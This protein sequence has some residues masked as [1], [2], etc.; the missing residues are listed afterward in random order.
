MALAREYIHGATV[1]GTDAEHR[2]GING[3]GNP[4]KGRDNKAHSIYENSV[5]S[6]DLNTA[7]QVLKCLR[8][9]G[10]HGDRLWQTKLYNWAKDAFMDAYDSGECAE[11]WKRTW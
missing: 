11:A 4:S 6:G 1:G 3:G 10:E 2:R 9:G 7:R 5:E 8:P